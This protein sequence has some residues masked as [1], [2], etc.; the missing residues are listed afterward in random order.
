MPRSGKRAGVIARA[1][2]VDET[3]TPKVRVMMVP[4]Y[5]GHHWTPP[6]GHV[7]ASESEEDA[8]VRELREAEG[9]TSLQISW[10]KARFWLKGHQKVEVK[11]F[12]VDMP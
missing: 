11:Y 4:H 10:I 5:D 7:G 3:G 12:I 9:S 6:K 8:V 2:S 1:E